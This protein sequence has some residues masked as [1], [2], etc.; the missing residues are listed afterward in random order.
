MRFADDG[1][2]VSLAAASDA[3]ALLTTQDA[4][5]DG[6][7]TPSDTA[8]ADFGALFTA[9]PVYGADGPGSTVTSYAL[10][11]A[12]GVSN[13]DDSGFDSNGAQINLFDVGGVIY[14]ST[15]NL[16]ANAVTNAVFS[17]AVDS[18]GVV[19]LTQFAEIDHAVEGVTTAPFDDQLAVLA[20]GLV[21]LTGTTLT[22]DGDGDT[23]TDAKTIDLGGNVRFADDGPTVSLAA[24]SDATA[25]L[26][27][28]D[29]ETDGDPTPSDTATAD[30]GALFTATPVYGADG[31]G[32]T[33]TSYALSLAAGVSN[34]D[35]SGFDSNGA[36]INLF[37]VGG[38][39]YGS[40]TNL[41]ANAVTNA[42]FSLAVD[43]AGVVTLTQ[44]A[45]ID[46]AVE[47]VTTAPFDDQLAVLANGLVSLTGT[48]LTTDGDGDTATDAKTIDLGGNVRFADDG[49]T[50]SL[51]A[52]SDATALLTTQDAETDGDPTPS[53]TA[54]A[55][56]GA[57]FTATP[58]YGADG[59]GS[60]VTSYA[61]SLAAGVS[62]GD[63]S[64]F[65]S[66]GA[67]INLFDVGG[68]IYGS[69]TNLIANAVTNAVFSLA[70]DS[71]GVVTL[72]QFAEIDHAV[73][74]VTTAPFDDQL[75]VLA[76]GL[77]SL[78]GTTLTTDGDGDTATDAKTIDLGGNVRFADDGPTVSLAAASDATALLT[79]QDA[80]TDGDPT[81]SDTATA[82][83]GALFTATPVYG[84]DGP[85]S[86]VTSYALSLAAGVSN[87]DDS[88]FDSNGAQINLFDVGGVIYGSTTN[89][90]A[91]AVTNAVFSLA[92]DSAGVVTLTQFAEIDHAVEGVTTA[93][94]DDQL[95]VLANGLVSLTGTTLTTD[96]DGDTAT[97]AKTIDLGGNVRFADD[98]PTVSLAAASDAT[99]LLTTQDAETDGDPTPSDTATADFGALFTATPVY[100]ADGPG[101]T[102]TSYALSLAAGV[103]NGDDSGF[104]SNG[105]QINLFDVGGVI[106]GS[107]T[108]LIANAVTNA[109][110]SLAVDSA[111]VVTLTQFAEIDHA[112]EGATTAPFDDQLAGPRQRSGD[113][114]GI[115][116]DHRWRRR[117]RHRRRPDRSRR[118]CPLRRRR[119]GGRCGRGERPRG[120][121]HAGRR[122][123]RRLRRRSDTATRRD[124]GGVFSLASSAY[125]AD[126][127]GTRRR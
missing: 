65:D 123:G 81:P 47:G 29:A 42:V 84:A 72:T 80:E 82:D 93:P 6:D 59:P 31:P 83:F 70:V 20:N 43:S 99:A 102:V 9:T 91:N 62:N 94:F 60:T 51:A 34:G 58:V 27:T 114:D 106:Y 124:F 26:T 41:I 14:G 64:G 125:G 17:L 77:V 95:A 63:D 87:G 50:V 30:F 120:A 22:T 96:G 86:T 76:N 19:T 48:T 97:D 53:D 38:V 23:A 119:P 113:A 8:T 18:A 71:A 74:G 1:P 85:G 117:Y 116:D 126:G 10:S 73:E 88:G 36:Q 127:A 13:G 37:D 111:G 5:T 40:T 100:G 12:A 118:Q 55:D 56:F 69:T 24:A 57:L 2:T 3:T 54:T 79:T 90:I 68:V 16:I 103:S 104:D 35:D 52:A 28:Q 121:D 15:T 7:P 92:V 11:L 78:T 108:N 44:F 107:T 61:L 98:G 49:P 101:S 67:Q 32:S 122:D 112:V 33:V 89:L 21:S 45:E 110:F 4:E 105:A 115:G 46:H 39:I 25:L 66:N 109:V 75:A